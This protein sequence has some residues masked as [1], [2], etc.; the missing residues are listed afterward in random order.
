MRIEQLV[1]RWVLKLKVEIS[2]LGTLMRLSPIAE[3][4]VDKCASKLSLL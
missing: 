2:L 4:T 3:I 1:C